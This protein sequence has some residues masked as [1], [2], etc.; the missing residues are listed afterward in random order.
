MIRDGGIC[1]MCSAKADEINHRLNRGAGGRK[2]LNR[3]DNACALCRYHNRVIESDSVE[4]RNARDLGVKLR[5]G[6]SYQ[7]PLWSPF[8]QR[9]L[10]L[11]DTHSTITEHRD[12]R[13]RPDLPELSPAG[14]VAYP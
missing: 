3:L 6:D 14:G 8:F 1:C 11:Y 10:I 9:W 5:E 13:V 4:G 12:P 7:T 2:S